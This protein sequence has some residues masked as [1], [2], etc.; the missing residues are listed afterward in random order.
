M[1]GKSFE[2]GPNIRIKQ[3]KLYAIITP[4]EATISLN[5]NRYVCL[6]IIL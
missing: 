2:C 6:T 4:V 5:N 3:H 1:V